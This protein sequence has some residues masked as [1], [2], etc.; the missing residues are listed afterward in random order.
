[1]FKLYSKVKKN[2]LLLSLIKKG[3][4]T[5][6]RQDLSPAEEFIQ[7]S[8]KKIISNDLFKAHKHLASEKSATTTQES[9][10][11]LDGKVL[12]TIYDVDDQIVYEEILE[13]GDCIVLFSGGHSLECLSDEAILYEFKNGPY[14]GAKQDK[15][16][17]EIDSEKK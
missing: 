17:L 6:K 16:Y 9:W 3:D 13:S 15:I 12:A 5:Y 14:Y 11:I 7:V 8:A 1:M 2:L 10:V 4:I